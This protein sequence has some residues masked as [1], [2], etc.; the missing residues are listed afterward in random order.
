M[1]DNKI[2]GIDVSKHTGD[3][4]WDIIKRQGVD[5]AYIKSTEGA[6]YIDPRYLYNLKEAKSA[7]IPVGAY[8]FFRFHRSGKEQA[9]NF[10][11]QVNI[12]DLDLP[13]VVDVEEWGQYSFSKNVENV[14]TEIQHFINDIESKTNRKVVIYSDKTTFR[15]YIDGKFKNN[16]I[17]I[18]SLGTPPQIDQK[19]TLWQQSH[20]GRCVGTS[21]IVDIN[22]F[23]GDTKE[24]QEFIQN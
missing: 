16:R 23:N 22:L 15:K 17:W 8:H 24:W 9:D 20:R 19:W 4:N 11:S 13:P 14:T 12:K 21:G 6:D 2:I 10:L 1:S 18:C 5:F 3:I 7:G